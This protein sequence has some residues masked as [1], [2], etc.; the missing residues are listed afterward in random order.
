M[1]GRAGQSALDGKSLI[2]RGGEMRGIV[3]MV[4]AAA[5]AAAG[6]AEAKLGGGDIVLSVSGAANVLYSHDI[7]AGKAKIGCK[8]CH[9]RLFT[10]RANHR[11]V[12]MDEMRKGLSCGAC[13]N[14]KRAFTVTDPK[15]CSK[16]HRG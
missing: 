5:L 4:L 2:V 13:H 3:L 11:T 12:T 1:P 7:H 16:C 15:Q 6:V 9:Y 10:N 8:E 14:G